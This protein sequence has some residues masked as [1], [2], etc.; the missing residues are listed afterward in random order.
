MN[1]NRPTKCGYTLK[2]CLCCNV[3]K[4]LTSSGESCY[5]AVCFQYWLSI[6]YCSHTRGKAKKGNDVIGFLNLSLENI[7]HVRPKPQTMS[8]LT[9]ENNQIKFYNLMTTVCNNITFNLCCNWSIL[10][11]LAYQIV[12]INFRLSRNVWQ[13]LLYLLIL[14]KLLTPLK[15]AHR[16]FPYPWLTQDWSKPNFWLQ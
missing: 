10:R 3:L 12:Q 5:T 16:P 13:L 9:G 11:C 6:I 8:Q 1:N 15:S 4:P 7:S 14:K 2:A